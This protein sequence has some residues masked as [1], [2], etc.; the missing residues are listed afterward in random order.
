MPRRAILLHAHRAQG[1]RMV[2]L[3]SLTSLHVTAIRDLGVGWDVV[4]VADIRSKI[5][6]ELNWMSDFRYTAQAL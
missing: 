4:A 6:G 5:G 3:A 2:I 1:N